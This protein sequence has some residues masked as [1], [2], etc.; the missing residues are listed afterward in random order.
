MQMGS[1]AKQIV[2][3]LGINKLSVNMRLK[4]NHDYLACIVNLF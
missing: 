2:L 3:E 4:I 1:I